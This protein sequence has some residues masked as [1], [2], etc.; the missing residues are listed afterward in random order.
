ME[1]ILLAII[2]YIYLSHADNKS[3][4]TAQPIVLNEQETK[5]K[6]NMQNLLKHF[7]LKLN[8]IIHRYNFSIDTKIIVPLIFTESGNNYLTKENSSVSGDGGR[9][10]GFM[11]IGQGALTDVNREYKT[12]YSFQDLKNEDV[13][14]FAGS[15][16]LNMCFEDAEQDGEN[17]PIYVA[18]KKYNGGIDETTTSKNT[19]ATT[20]ANK[21]FNYYKILVS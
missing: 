20:Y 5:D 13:N 3:V 16:Y 11:Q 17:N 12:N 9:S 2:V 21:V 15:A 7:S 19:L 18:Y 8:N 4:S 1:I 10:I 6:I 14:L